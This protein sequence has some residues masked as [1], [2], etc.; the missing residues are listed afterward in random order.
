MIECL[1]NRMGWLK[2]GSLI[3]GAGNGI[4][5]QPCP[6]GQKW[7]FCGTEIEKQLQ[8]LVLIHKFALSGQDDGLWV[9]KCYFLVFYTIRK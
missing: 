8:K 2:T 9:L 7:Y 5:L 6:F 4:P 1:L 3:R